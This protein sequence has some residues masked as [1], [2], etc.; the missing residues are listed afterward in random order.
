[1]DTSATSSPLGEGASWRPG[2]A[3]F[4]AFGSL[5]VIT[6]A[7]AL[8]ATSL[9]VALPAGGPLYLSSYLTYS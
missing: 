1:M 3:F 4:A 6:L 7:A 9:S 8:D 5:L 2:F